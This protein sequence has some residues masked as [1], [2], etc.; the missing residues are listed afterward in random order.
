MF[1]VRTVWY[2]GGSDTHYKNNYVLL[3]FFL[4]PVIFA[5][6]NSSGHAVK[7]LLSLAHLLQKYL[8]TPSIRQFQINKNL[9]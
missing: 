3:I 2:V 9:E 6:I 8:C 5:F 4:S 7:E 1:Q